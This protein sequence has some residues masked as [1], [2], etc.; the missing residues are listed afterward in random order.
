M[1]VRSPTPTQPP[2]PA[3]RGDAQTDAGFSTHHRLT[4]DRGWRIEM[5]DREAVRLLGGG[6]RPAAELLGLGFWDVFSAFAGTA[7][8]QRFRAAMQHHAADDLEL[9]YSSE[10]VAIEVRIRP[11]WPALSFYVRE[12][13]EP[14]PG[15]NEPR[16][17]PRHPKETPL[18]VDLAPPRSANL[19]CSFD[20]EA[21]LTHASAALLECWGF[22]LSEARG[23]TLLELNYPSGV[24]EQLHRHIQSVI[25]TGRPSREALSYSIRSG[26]TEAHEHV[27][28]PL[29]GDDGA[30]HGVAGAI[31]VLAEHDAQPSHCPP[32]TV[33]HDHVQRAKILGEIAADFFAARPG[34]LPL[35]AVFDRIATALEAD[36]CLHH[37]LLEGGGRLSLEHGTGLAPEPR[38]RFAEL[39]LDEEPPGIVARQ[40]RPF[41]AQN[42]PTSLDPATATLRRFGFG[43]CACVPLQT[44]DRLLGTLL[45]A[46]RAPS[47]FGEAEL[48]FLHSASAL[49][50][51]RLCGETV[52]APPSVPVAEPAPAI[53]AEVLKESFLHAVAQELRAPLESTL[54]QVRTLAA[55]PAI[56]PEIRSELEGIARNL[57]VEARLVNDLGDLTRISRGELAIEKEPLDLHALVR[58]AVKTV[59]P[60]LAAQGLVLAS[61]LPEVAPT[62]AGDPIRLQQ[63]LWNLL[64]RA[65]RS[66]P[67]GGVVSV[68]LSLSSDRVACVTITDSGNGLSANAAARVFEPWVA[69]ESDSA[70]EPGQQF[71]FGMATVRKI[72]E[73][74]GGSVC[75][76]HPKS[77]R[78]TSFVVELPLAPE[79]PAPAPEV[80]ALRASPIPR[81]RAADSTDPQTT[82]V[83]LV[84]DHPPTRDALL[85]LLRQRGYEVLVAASVREARGLAGQ[86][87]FDF[88][89][90]AITLPDG[91]GYELMAALRLDFG[92]SGIAL[93]G[94]GTE[95]DSALGRTAGFVAR[96]ARPVSVEALERALAAQL[97]DR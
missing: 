32:D 39:A 38:A 58:D 72:V 52:S 63:V 87:R 71:G 46:T 30:V 68:R 3:R 74:H 44:A 31:R 79:P 18:V 23:R 61:N 95:Q 57:A 53:R 90:A 50:S 97:S 78:G 70:S 80:R 19:V 88:V 25:T 14:R 48:R 93:V 66:T 85:V 41:V 62:I 60:D 28:S 16:A 47:G 24:A 76:L 33:V 9:R 84:E 7:V 82:R 64:K 67:R 29:L 86:H 6:D 92:L 40:Q 12:T 27:F 42:L 75:V 4:V 73:L 13:S 77:G 89:I 11:R 26:R 96:L 56:S 65:V 10:G 15:A 55:N 45:L 59:K 83:L 2:L 91:S 17:V 21:R 49:I 5:I 35:T 20:R 22:R 36:V 94:N 37:R 1:S 81:P 69:A 34:R 8:E 54:L 51:A 43:A